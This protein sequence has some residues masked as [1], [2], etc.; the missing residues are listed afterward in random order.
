MGQLKR[1]GTLVLIGAGKDPLGLSPSRILLNELV[2]TGAFVYDYDGFERALELLGRP[3]FP[4]DDLIEANDVP[5]DGI[6]EA[7]QRLGAGELAA[8][9]MI[10]PPTS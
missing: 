2:I 4:T 8:K 1:G 6:F 9:V 10:V 3:D 7:I 5:L